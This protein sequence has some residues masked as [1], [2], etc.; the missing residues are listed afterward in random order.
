ML[1]GGERRVSEGAVGGR[2]IYLEMLAM[3]ASKVS[4]ERKLSWQA[5]KAQ[6]RSRFRQ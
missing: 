1:K 2:E 4:S 3:G 6:W 5:D